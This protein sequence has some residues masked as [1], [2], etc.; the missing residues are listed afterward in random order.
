VVQTPTPNPFPPT[1]VFVS[2]PGDPWW[3]ILLDVL[4]AAGTIAAAVA[5]VWAAVKAGRIA[6]ADREAADRR[7]QEERAHDRERDRLRHRLDSLV[8]LVSAYEQWRALPTQ[9]AGERGQAYG[10]F[11]AQLRG[12]PPGM[13]FTRRA[14]L[15]TSEPITPEI[16]RNFGQAYRLGEAQPGTDRSMDIERHEMFRELDRARA[17]LFG[18]PE[19]EIEWS[20]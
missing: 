6:K 15:R 1:A 3:R 13:P 7:A 11:L 8:A 20:D 16:L 12:S 17:A 9:M 4:I 18:E 14:Y 5:A 10:T 19:E 2:T